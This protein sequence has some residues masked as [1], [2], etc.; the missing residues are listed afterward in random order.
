MKPSFIVVRIFLF[1]VEQTVT[2]QLFWNEL[3]GWLVERLA[4]QRFQL[5]RMLAGIGDHLLQ[6]RQLIIEIS[7]LLINKR[8]PAPDIEAI[9]KFRRR[10]LKKIGRPLHIPSIL[11]ARNASRLTYRFLIGQLKIVFPRRLR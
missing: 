4:F 6:R 2:V 3:A 9:G 10:F 5:R 1:L 7:A 11:L 8:E